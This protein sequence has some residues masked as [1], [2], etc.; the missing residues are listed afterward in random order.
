MGTN[1]ASASKSELIQ[2]FRILR[3]DAMIHTEVFDGRKKASEECRPEI[4]EQVPESCGHFYR[5]GIPQC[6][7]STPL[8]P[9]LALIVAVW[10]R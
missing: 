8:E 1:A 3:L 10:D 5:E 2:V 7:F 4:V 9:E 6:M